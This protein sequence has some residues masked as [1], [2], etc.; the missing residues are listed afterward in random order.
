MTTYSNKATLPN[1]A[2]PSGPTRAISIQATI[3]G[4]HWDLKK[5][6]RSSYVIIL[7]ELFRIS[8]DSVFS[9]VAPAQSF[10][11]HIE[12]IF[13]NHS[14]FERHLAASPNSLFLGMSQQS[15]LGGGDKK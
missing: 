15:S 12:H 13:F 11:V 14:L 3:P 9:I 8:L 5:S 6:H 1:S 4:I 10:Y 2:T 7:D